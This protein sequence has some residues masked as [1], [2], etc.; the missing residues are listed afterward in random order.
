[1][2]LKDVAAQFFQRSDA[3]QTFWGFYITISLALLAF[4]GNAPRTKR[5]AGILTAAFVGVATV[6]LGGLI[7]V[8][9][10]RLALRDLL[11]EAVGPNAGRFYSTPP[12]P[13]LASVYVNVAGAPS[14][15]GIVGTHLFC[16]VVVITAI[17]LLTL[18]PLQNDKEP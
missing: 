6:N 14:L 11:R 16:D 13:A 8:A 7:V 2:D 10:Q 18:R 17:W 1:M 15:I 9:R 5:L 4:F 3:M 12:K